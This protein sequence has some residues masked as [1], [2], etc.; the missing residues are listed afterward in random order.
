MTFWRSNC[1]SNHIDATKARRIPKRSRIF[2]YCIFRSWYLVFHFL[3]PHFLV[4]HF[5]RPLHTLSFRQ[6]ACPA[7]GQANARYSCTGAAWAEFISSPTALCP[8]HTV[9]HTRLVH[10]S[11]LCDPIQSNPSAD[12]PN[13]LQVEK[14]GPNPTQ[15]NTTNNGA[16]S[17]VVFG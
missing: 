13:L 16:Y 5:Q 4:L 17:L 9:H 7:A 6:H 11:I 1:P 15:P 10:G 2:R 8:V 14:F 12:W 3:V